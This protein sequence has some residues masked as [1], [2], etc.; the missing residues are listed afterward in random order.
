MPLCCFCLLKIVGKEKKLKFEPWVA[1]T[2][3]NSWQTL[4][5]FRTSSMVFMFSRL[6]F[7]GTG[8]EVKKALMGRHW[9]G[10]GTRS[11][12]LIWKWKSALLVLGFVSHWLF[13][14]Y[15]W[16]RSQT[17]AFTIWKKWWSAYMG[18]VPLRLGPS[19][20]G[21]DGDLRKEGGREFWNCG[22]VKLLR[23]SNSDL[24]CLG[25]KFMLRIMF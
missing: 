24:D 3:R 25:L 15:E 6:C 16:E 20:K 8:L 1:K 21:L 11:L 23:N 10:F 4:S 9:L 18:G 14:H 2:C 5:N 22:G 7:T 12:N 13:N 17:V 19:G